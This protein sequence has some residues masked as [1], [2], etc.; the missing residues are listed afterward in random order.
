MPPS[1]S[2]TLLCA[3]LALLICNRAGVCQSSNTSAQSIIEKM[4]AQ[5]ANASS[6][7]DTGVVDHVKG[8]RANQR[9]TAIKFKTFYA[10]PHFFRFEFT[11]RSVVSSEERLNVVWN[12]G[13]QTYIYYSWDGKDIGEKEN[14]SL[15]IAGA[16]GI[17]EGSTLR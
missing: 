12:D 3:L 13:K 7:Q 5:Y 4:A 1:K 15:G 9:E 6:Y 8:E 17:S 10:R 16:T 2:F 11:D 14:L